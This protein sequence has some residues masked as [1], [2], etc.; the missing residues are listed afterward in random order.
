MPF[1][2]SPI[3]ALRGDSGPWIEMIARCQQKYRA[4]EGC[5]EWCQLVLSGRGGCNGNGEEG[6]LEEK[7]EICPKHR[8]ADVGN[9]VEDVVVIVPVDADVEE[10][11]DVA[12]EDREDCRK[13]CPVGTF[14]DVELKHHDRDDDGEDSVGE[15]FEAVLLHWS[16]L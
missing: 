12:K 3:A 9:G 16:G 1:Q 4:V 8:R 14:G 2:S 15:S 6:K 5:W 7:V 13:S 11:E 10:A